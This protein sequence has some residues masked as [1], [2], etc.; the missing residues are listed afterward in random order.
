MRLYEGTVGEFK[1]DVLNNEIADIVAKNYLEKIQRKVNESEYRS[2]ESSL[3]V[4]KDSL[5]TPELINNK[6]VIEYKLP[7]SERRIDIV[8]FGKSIDNK[9][10][11][12][13]IELKQWSNN[14]VKDTEIEGNLEID[15]GNHISQSEHPCFQV[16]AYVIDMNDFIKVFQDTPKIE[17]WWVVF[18]VIIIP[19]QK[20][21]FCM[22]KSFKMQ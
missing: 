17:L 11:I 5:D 14:S 20:I 22:L 10:T 6:I 9:D 4:L 16:E 1:R 3:R 19:E 7:Y 21:Q 18:T 12:V 8:L 2:C 15:Y 13:I